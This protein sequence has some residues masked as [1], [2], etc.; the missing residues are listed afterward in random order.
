MVKLRPH[1]GMRVLR[2]IGWMAW[3]R[4]DEYVD[5]ALAVLE[6]FEVNGTIF[7]ALSALLLWLGIVCP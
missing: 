3:Q 1:M 7:L 2:T 6:W 5:A 4:G